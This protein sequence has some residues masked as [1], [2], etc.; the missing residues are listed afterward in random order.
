[1]RLDYYV[2]NLTQE[3]KIAK[4]QYAHNLAKEKEMRGQW[5]RR[6]QVKPHDIY[7]DI[8]VWNEKRIIIINGI[9]Y[10]FADI[11]GCD[12]S[13]KEVYKEGKLDHAKIAK[14]MRKKQ[15]WGEILGG[16]IGMVVGTVLQPLRA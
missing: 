13:S 15:V 11:T 14:D 9:E 10:S 8:A 5:D 1:M 3:R 7:S 4:E 2:V 12:L 6:I 16:K